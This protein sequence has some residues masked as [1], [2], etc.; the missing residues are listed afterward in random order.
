MKDNSNP[1]SKEQELCLQ[2]LEA[3]QRE[4]KIAVSAIAHNSLPEFEQSLWRQEMLC[5]GLKRLLLAVRRST[6]EIDDLGRL[7]AAGGRLR[8]LN[9]TYEGLVRRATQSAAQLRGLCQL[10]TNVPAPQMRPATTS[11]S[12]EA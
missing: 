11:L 5:A 12:C 3:L 6:R 10:Y 8:T 7:Q 2:H 9:R 4:V 1:A